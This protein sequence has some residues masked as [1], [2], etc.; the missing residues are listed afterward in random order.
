MTADPGTYDVTPP[1]SLRG[2]LTLAA[3]LTLA[4]IAVALAALVL[5]GH[6]ARL[7]GV[8]VIGLPACV[9]GMLLLARGPRWRA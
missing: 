3:I 5:T 9:V 4:V 7:G 1:P 8:S 2:S 6:T